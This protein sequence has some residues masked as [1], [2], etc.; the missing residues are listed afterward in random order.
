LLLS[1]MWRP[2][3]I[4][5]GLHITDHNNILNR[6]LPT[7][8]PDLHVTQQVQKSSLMMAHRCRNM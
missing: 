6:V 5:P 3:A 2:G 8:D 1:V 4:A 7:T